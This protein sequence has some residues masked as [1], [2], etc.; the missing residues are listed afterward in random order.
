RPTL[1]ANGRLRASGR[2]SSRA[3][4]VV[5]LQLEYFADGKTTTLPL[6]ARIDDGRWSINERLSDSVRA[7]IARRVGT[8]HSYVLFT[9]YLPARM[10]GEMRSL[11]VL[12]PR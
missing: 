5:R 2:I 12:G 9:G 6:R 10:R 11:Q 7:A 8:V 1:A 3:R 4:G